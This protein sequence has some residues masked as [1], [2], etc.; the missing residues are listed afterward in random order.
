MGCLLKSVVHDCLVVRWLW[1]ITQERH[2][3][4]SDGVQLAWLSV[5]SEVQSCVCGPADA[6]V[7]DCLLFQ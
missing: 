4:T 6:T 3:T 5:W 1:R 2:T 7:S